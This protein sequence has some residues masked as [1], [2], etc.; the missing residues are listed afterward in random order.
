M[1]YRMLSAQ[2]NSSRW[3]YQWRA[4]ECVSV[5]WSLMQATLPT[6]TSRAS[7]LLGPPHETPIHKL[8]CLSNKLTC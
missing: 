4:R 2:G 8:D 1:S 3:W 7:I 5:P 6:C